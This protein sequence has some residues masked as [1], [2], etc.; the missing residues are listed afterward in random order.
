L[1]LV[2]RCLK[3]LAAAALKLNATSNATSGCSTSSDDRDI[4]LI[5]S[6]VEISEQQ[7]IFARSLAVLREFLKAYQLKPQ[8]ATPKTARLPTATVQSCVE[9][10]PLTVK[11]QSFDGGKHTEVKSLTLGKLNNAATLFASL[12]RATGF[13]NYRVYCGGKVFDP[14]EIEIS[15]SLDE[16]NLNG[17]VLVHRRE[18][19][20]GGLSQGN[21]TS[22]ELE[23]MKHFDDLWG[24]LGMH[25]KVAQE[26]RS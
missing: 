23:I 11:Y 3:Q 20:E 25:D 9:G 2:D 7:K 15:K 19:T 22:L 21:K 13:T 24:Y 14:E 17:L 1:A 5:A 18:E 10:E 16:L 6:D 4:V 12:E 8:F 26:V